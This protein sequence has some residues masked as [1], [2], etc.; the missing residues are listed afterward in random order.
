MLPIKGI[1]PP[2][3]TPFDQ[4]GDLYPGML[5]KN[6]DL[7]NAFDLS[8]YLVLGSNGELVM[9][10]DKERIQVLETA[11]GIIPA[12]KLLM[13]GTG[14]QST[15]QT[16]EF[17]NK[18]SAAGADVALVLN[19]YYYKN[20][21]TRAALVNHF[22]R[23]ADASSIPVMIYNMPANTGIDMDAETIYEISQHPNVIGLKDSGGNVAKIG[24]INRMC[25]KDFRIM[26]GGAGFF[27]PAL[28]VGATGG[29]LALA[30]VAPGL[31]I[32][33]NRLFL[34]GEMGKA[35]Q[36]QAR[37][38]PLNSAITRKWGISALKEAM[39]ILGM[40]GGPAREPL[41]SL[42]QSQKNELK[43]LLSETGILK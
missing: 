29:I 15:R 42:D 1:I 37:L 23:V 24:D 40:Y 9:L 38:I 21:M 14:C 13:A 12:E 16:I 25:G 7:L 20:A 30:N 31:C 10:S 43:Q 18:A 3:P 34:Q 19:P 8:G 39:D 11:R 35:K 36:L 2:L 26:A 28:T 41:L 32:E 6:I 4:Q 22:K 17:T 5:R 33:L 27:L